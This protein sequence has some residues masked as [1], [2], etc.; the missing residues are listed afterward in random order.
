MNCKRCGIEF[1]PQH[2]ASKHCSV[3]SCLDRDVRRGKK[4]DPDEEQSCIRCGTVFTGKKKKYCCIECRHRGESDKQKQNRTGRT[5]KTVVCNMCKT[6]FTTK[7]GDI[8]CSDNCRN[9]ARSQQR[10]T[11]TKKQFIKTCPVCNQVYSTAH[12]EQIYCSKI[13]MGISMRSPLLLEK[14]T[15]KPKTCIDCGKTIKKTQKRCVDCVRQHARLKSYQI[16]NK[17]RTCRYCKTT[18]DYQYKQTIK[19]YCCEEHRD[20]AAKQQDKDTKRNRRTKERIRLKASFVS[21]VKYSD[22]YRRDKGVCQLC[23]KKISDRCQWPDLMC[24]S[25]DHII[26]LSL[27]GTHEPKNVQLAHFMCNSRK[28][29]RAMGEQLRLC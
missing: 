17:T 1:Q 8:Y 7:Q 5:T 14:A 25:L 3:C 13:C 11:T 2:H 16:A 26:P 29:N 21:T 12:V 9:M 23:G 10:K 4:K 28:G 15:D 19:G 6:T 18:Y 20:L 27:G 22:I 24:G